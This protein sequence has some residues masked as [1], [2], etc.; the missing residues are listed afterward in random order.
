MLR[1]YTGNLPD[2]TVLMERCLDLI[3]QD[4]LNLAQKAET[5]SSAEMK[6]LPQQ[7]KTKE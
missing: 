2:E 5:S 6:P 4:K 3:L 1:M 7:S